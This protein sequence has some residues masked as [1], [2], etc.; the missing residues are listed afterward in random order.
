MIATGNS[1]FMP[2]L[3]R[4]AFLLS[5]KTCI[6]SLCGADRIVR[7]HVLVRFAGGARGLILASQVVAG[8]E[9]GR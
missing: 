6:G 8:E 3:V 5:R 1:H 4:M 2:N 7:P 9:N